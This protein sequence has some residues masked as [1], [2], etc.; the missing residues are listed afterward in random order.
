MKEKSFHRDGVKAREVEAC[1]KRRERRRTRG[2]CVRGGVGGGGKARRRV[3][4]TRGPLLGRGAAQIGEV[5]SSIAGGVHAHRHHG[6]R[7]RLQTRNPGP[8]NPMED[9]I[10]TLPRSGPGPRR[11]GAD[12]TKQGGELQR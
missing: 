6:R 10:A 4:V 7:R 2:H 12:G 9:V 8:P 1:M 5:I 3:S 11:R